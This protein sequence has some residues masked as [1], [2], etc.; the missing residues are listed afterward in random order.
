MLQ[1]RSVASLLLILLAPVSGYSQLLGESVDVSD[2]F[3]KNDSTYFVPDS[4]ASYDE[5]S[6]TGTV[7]WLRHRREY[8]VSFN[9]LDT[10]FVRSESNEFPAV[11]YDRDPELPFA[12]DFI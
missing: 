9:K 1:V 5:H 4:V 12:V 8:N 3:A 11:E 10:H 6:G 2:D 7:R